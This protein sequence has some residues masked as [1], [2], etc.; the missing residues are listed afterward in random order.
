MSIPITSTPAYTY[1]YE[2][3][4]WFFLL[5]AGE[6]GLTLV[7]EPRGGEDAEAT[8]PTIPWKVEIQSKSERGDLDLLLLLEWLWKFPDRDASNSLLERLLSNPQS[9][10]LF[11]T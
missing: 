4:V 11:V 7:N 9:S 5:H 3:V 10:A 6:L 8:F 1:Q 2:A